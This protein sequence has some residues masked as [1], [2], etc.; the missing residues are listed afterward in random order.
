MNPR[1]PL[2]LHLLDSH[3]H[4]AVMGTHICAAPSVS[5]ETFRE[6][7]FIQVSNLAQQLELE[8][9]PPLRPRSQLCLTS[10]LSEHAAKDTGATD[11]PTL[12]EAFL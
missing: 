2:E 4:T 9:L 12:E 1:L 5:R 10:L 8:P 7:R 6:H 11:A 3:S